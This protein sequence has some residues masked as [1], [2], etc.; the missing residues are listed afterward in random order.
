M[1]LTQT[2]RVEAR[3]AKRLAR[4]DTS[5]RGSCSPGSVRPATMSRY[6]AGGSDVSNTPSRLGG[7]MTVRSRQCSKATIAEVCAATRPKTRCGISI[8]V[9]HASRIALGA[10]PCAQS[11]ARYFVPLGRVE[12]MSGAELDEKNAAK[13]QLPSGV[14]GLNPSV[15]T[16]GQSYGGSS[17]ESPAPLSAHGKQARAKHVIAKSRFVISLG[18]LR[19]YRA[20]NALVRVISRLAMRHNVNRL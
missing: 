16:L 5:R 10:R 8:K 7:L 17:H 14:F 20:S 4:Q 13:D 19:F 2:A 12:R 9:Q 11:V 3:G 1:P 6:G 18:L 15:A